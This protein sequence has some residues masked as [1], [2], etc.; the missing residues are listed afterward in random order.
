MTTRWNDLVALARE[1]E[2]ARREN[3]PIEPQKARRLARAV[4]ALQ[5]DERQRAQGL[6][7]DRDDSA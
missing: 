6:A 4:L 3:K 5:L 1:I 2:Q 7:A